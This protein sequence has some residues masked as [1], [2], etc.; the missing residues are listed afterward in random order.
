MQSMSPPTAADLVQAAIA[1]K[2]RITFAE[3]MEIALYTP[4]AGY[5]TAPSDRRDENR[6]SSVRHFGES[7]NPES[8][9]PT[10]PPHDYYTAPH[11]HAVFGTFIARHVAQVWQD[12][13]E[14]PQFDVVE[15]GAGRGIMAWDI[16]NGLR[17][18]APECWQCTRYQVI[19]RGPGPNL[20]QKEALAA[21]AA[22]PVLVGDSAAAPVVGVVLS[23]ELLDALPV[24][25]VRVKSGELQELYVTERD[26][27]F[28][29][30]FGNPSRP[31]LAHYVERLGRP[32]EGWQGE[33]CLAALAWLEEVARM[34]TKGTVITIDYGATWQELCSARWVEG[35]LA[36]YFRHG[37]HR[38][39]YVRIGAQDITAHVNFSALMKFGETAGL[40]TGILQSQAEYLLGLGIGEKLAAL[41][42]QPF[43]AET[44]RAKRAITDLIWPDGLGGFRVLVQ[45]KGKA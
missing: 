21:A 6:D 26:G 31:Y 11:I 34:L 37:V 12:L 38:N 9:L 41:A 42:H 30:E 18:E 13:G 36:C 1:E 35:T 28:R 27:A 4:G 33:I 29:E 45:E 15:M 40:G 19:D 44:Q 39:P 43:T 16:L 24:H 14:P 8:V 22:Q 20:A 17:S 5:Y 3:F 2:D 25:R 10:G 23:N 7:R 32:P